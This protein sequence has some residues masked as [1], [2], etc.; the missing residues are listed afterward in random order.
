MLFFQENPK[1]N[2]LR[3]Y[4]ERVL[5]EFGTSNEGEFKSG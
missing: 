1:M 2:Y 3:D 5:Q 4:Y